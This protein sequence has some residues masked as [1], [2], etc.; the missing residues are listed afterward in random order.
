MIKDNTAGS[1]EKTA[2]IFMEREGNH[3]RHSKPACLK[4]LNNVSAALRPSARRH[5]WIENDRAVM[6]K[7]H[8]VIRKHRIGRVEFFFVLDHD[9]FNAGFFQPALK[10]VELPARGVRSPCDWYP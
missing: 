5:H 3:A 10:N 2:L 6:V 9:D 1:L 7:R 4:R 8:P